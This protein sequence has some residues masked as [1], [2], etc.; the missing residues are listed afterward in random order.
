MSSGT[1]VAKVDRYAG[2]NQKWAQVQAAARLSVPSFH[3][4][5]TAFDRVTL[6]DLINTWCSDRCVTERNAAKLV[7][8]RKA[9]A[10]KRGGTSASGA[11]SGGTV[12]GRAL[13]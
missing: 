5:A 3:G 2:R 6:L 7:E 8:E 4:D 12:C 11:E 1:A 13:A 9:N 10:C